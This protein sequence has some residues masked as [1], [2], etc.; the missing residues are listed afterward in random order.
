MNWAGRVLPDDGTPSVEDVMNDTTRPEWIR[1]GAE[2]QI[3]LDKVS[4]EIRS[5]F[6]A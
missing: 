6:S 3:A 1:R 5:R 2:A 4:A